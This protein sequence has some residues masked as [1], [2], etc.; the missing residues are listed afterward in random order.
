MIQR[1][2]VELYIVY[3]SNNGIHSRI[4]RVSKFID[5]EIEVYFLIHENICI[6]KH[7]IDLN[8]EL[9]TKE[10]Q[11]IISLLRRPSAVGCLRCSIERLMAY[12]VSSIG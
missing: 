10:K 4:H 3:A 2:S 7:W 9:F 6:C 1:K 11:F 12:S 5:F 8:G